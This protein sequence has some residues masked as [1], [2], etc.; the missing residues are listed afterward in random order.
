MNDETNGARRPLAVCPRDVSHKTFF[1]TATVMEEW[2]VNEFGDF[3]KSNATIDVADEPDVRNQWLCCACEEAAL[4]G[5][6]AREFLNH[7]QQKET[8]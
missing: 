8:P 2:L 7:H 5:D 3:I 1:T 4:T 6:A